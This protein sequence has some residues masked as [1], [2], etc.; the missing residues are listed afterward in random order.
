[1]LIVLS[2]HLPFV[3]HKGQLR[4]SDYEVTTG[5]ILH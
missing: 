1:M 2:A 3:K 5:L 4:G